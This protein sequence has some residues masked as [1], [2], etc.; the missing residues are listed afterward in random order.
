MHHDVEVCTNVG[1]I[2]TLAEIQSLSWLGLSEICLGF[3][4]NLSESKT[5]GNK[6]NAFGI[7]GNLKG[8]LKWKTSIC[9]EN[10]N[11]WQQN[12]SFATGAQ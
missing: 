5:A 12:E 3:K 1:E 9:I 8:Q 10:E 11:F 2:L 4:L 6:P 7:S